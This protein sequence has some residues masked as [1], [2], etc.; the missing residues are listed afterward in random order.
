VVRLPPPLRG[1]LGLEEFVGWDAQGLG[2]GVG[3][4]EVDALAL[5]GLKG[6]DGTLANASKFGEAQLGKALGFSQL[7][8]ADAEWC[9]SEKIRRTV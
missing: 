6:A 5:A 1:G 7:S 8:E 4:G 9:H 3:R 2:E